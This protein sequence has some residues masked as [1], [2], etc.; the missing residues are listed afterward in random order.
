MSEF[1]WKIYVKQGSLINDYKTLKKYLIK[2]SL[3]MLVE[4]TGV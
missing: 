1:E 3:D 2:Q 4:D